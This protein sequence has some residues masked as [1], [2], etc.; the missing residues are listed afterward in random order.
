MFGE[1]FSQFSAS[2]GLALSLFMAGLAGGFTHC[3][4]MCGSFVL[5]QSGQGGGFVRR[6]LLP[7][8]LGRVSTYVF[9]AIIFSG[10]VNLAFFFKPEYRMLVGAPLLVS[11][12]LV[13]LI[14]AFPQLG[15]MFPWNMRLPFPVSGLMRLVGTLFSSRDPFRRYVL[16]VMLGFMPCGMVVSAL[17]AAVTAPTVMQ[18]AVAMIAFGAGTMPALLVLSFGGA[19][20]RVFSPTF[21]IGVRRA[22]MVISALWLFVLA[23]VM[24]L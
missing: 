17:M 2:Y 20:M 23:G 13:F 22:F 19:Y 4:V 11:A 1:C 7:Y 14:S 5:A 12:G 24:V 10:F 6:I 15:R 21:G 9:L 16:G 8:H 18:S 3:G